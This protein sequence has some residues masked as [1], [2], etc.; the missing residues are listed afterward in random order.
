MVYNF[1]ENEDILE[2][3]LKEQQYKIQKKLEKQER[4]KRKKLLLDEI[5]N[6]LDQVKEE[7]KFSSQSQFFPTH[8]KGSLEWAFSILNSELNLSLS[9][10]KKNYL[11]LAQ[12]YHPD[13]N[14]GQNIQEM[15]DL[16]EAW[17]IVRKKNK[18]CL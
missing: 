3:Q 15:K 11:Q 16:N 4:L 9:D 12:Q 18:P 7:D 8:K 17:E 10:I 2:A 5:K 14:N 13:K 6:T 1:S